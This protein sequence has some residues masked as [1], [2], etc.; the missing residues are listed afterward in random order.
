MIMVGWSGVGRTA[1][2][3]R[4]VANKY[5]DLA[6]AGEVNEVSD[7]FEFT[8]DG[9]YGPQTYKLQITNPRV[10]S[11]SLF[12]KIENIDRVNGCIMVYDITDRDSFDSLA[13]W[14][15]VWKYLSF[16]LSLFLSF[17]PPLFHRI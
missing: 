5:S 15:K 12:D 10:S 4:L 6:F 8:I 3:N 16:T 11:E 1:L 13:Q 2:L 7:V 9:D 17:L 14:W